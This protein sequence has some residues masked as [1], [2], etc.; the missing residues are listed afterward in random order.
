MRTNSLRVAGLI[1]LFTANAALAQEF[2]AT[3]TGRIVDSSDAGIPAAAVSV[4]NIQTNEVTSATADAHGNYTAPFLRPGQYSI[5]VEAAGFNK[6]TRSGLVL[7]IGQA[8][9]VNITLEVGAVTQEISVTAATPLLEVSKADRGGIIDQQRVTELPLIFRNPFMLGQMVAGVVFA[10]T[11]IWQRPFD[12]GAIAEWGISGGRRRGTEFL[13]DG[14]PN[15]AQ[16]GVNNLAYVPPVDSVQEFKIHTN[17][18]DAQYGKTDGG[19]VNVSLKSGTNQLHGSIYEFARRTSWDANTFQNNAR[20]QPRTDHILDHYGFQ[21]QGPVYLPKVFNGKDRLFFMTNYERYRE[22]APYPVTESVPAS[23]FLTGDFSKLVDAQGRQIAIFDPASGRQVGNQWV[24]DAFAGNLIPQARINPVGKKILSYYPAPN[25]ITPGVGYT[26]TN[27]YAPDNWNRDDFYNVVFKFDVN[28]GDRH[29]AFFR[30]ARN[31]RTEN[32]QES[33][34]IMKGPGQTGEKPSYRINNHFTAD[35][36]ATL[37]PDFIFNLR[38]SFNRYVHTTGNAA[39]VGFDMSTFGFP[40]AML[41][42]LSRQDVF[43]YYSFD[44]YSTMGRH[45]GGNWTNTWAI[46][47]TATKISGSH[48]LKFG[49]DTRFTQYAERN[50]TDPLYFSTSRVFTQRQFNQSDA[51]SGSSIASFLLGFPSSG[52]ADFNAFPIYMYRYQAPYIQDDW[53][54]TRRLTLNLGFRW[55]LNY[56]ANERFDRLNRYFDASAVNPADKL[57]NR[58]AFPA[59]PQLRGGLLF[60]GVGG[61]PRTAADLYKRAFQPRFGLAYQIRPRIVFRGGWGRFYVNPSNSFLQ[62]NGF[63]ISTPYVASGD[64]S[65]TPLGS[66]SNP[67]PNGIQRPAGSS[68]GLSTFLGS[69]LS[70]VNPSFR[71][72][73]VNQ[74]S[75]GFQIELPGSRMVEITYVGNRSTDLENSRPFNEPSLAFR[76]LCNFYEGGAP[77]YCNAQLPNPFQGLAPFGVTGHYS[78]TTLGRLDLARPYPEFGS[79]TELMRND[80]AVWYNSLQ[81]THQAR[82]RGVNL[83]ATYTLAKQIEQL[84]WLDVQRNVLQRSPYES[85]TPHRITLANVWELPIG[86]GKRLLNTTHR[87]WSRVVSGWETAEFF[88]WASGRP[89]VMPSGVRYVRDARVENIDWSAPQVRGIKPCIARQNEDGTITPQAFSLTYG[90]GADVSTY[91]FIIQP[92]YAPTATPARAG[93][94]RVHSVANLD[95]SI[96]KRTQVTERLTIQFRAEAFNVTN[97]NQF[98]RENFVNNANNASFG[99][100]VRS[101]AAAGNGRPR[102]VQIAVKAIW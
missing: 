84:G 97:T 61:Q 39:N 28:V 6:V 17:T 30:Y 9:T 68:L 90:C 14:S 37:R 101:T 70:F 56:P 58:T 40:A 55:D 23:E 45:P 11:P 46:H 89:W 75:A 94:I 62:R 4:K 80:G 47:P 24:R 41:N 21:V 3:I 74:F 33:G 2:R 79:V 12:N 16:A 50:W 95:L 20:G 53:K 13:L 69:G 31:L 52:R 57:V 99:T 72:P 96:T 77:A 49:M 73:Y 64:E 36:V 35:W 67:F 48:A 51:L 93:N 18:Y 44:G 54:V 98:P 43:G 59:L 66:L 1:F 5:T 8:A 42:Q 25:S 82:F 19:I 27:Y 88:Q 76:Q 85:D 38:A 22:Q 87:F 7:N 78:R 10:G 83:L 92:Q 29:R 26:Q 91:N 63:S 60:A 65:R 71:L 102:N 15:N 86:R 34:A 32:T 100:I 81:V